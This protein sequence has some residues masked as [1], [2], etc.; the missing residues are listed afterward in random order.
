MAP[1]IAWKTQPRTTP[2]KM[3]G[4]AISLT[5]SLCTLAVLYLAAGN[6][7]GHPRISAHEAVEAVVKNVPPGL[8]IQGCQR[9]IQEAQRSCGV[10]AAATAGFDAAA[11]AAVREGRFGGGGASVRR[12]EISAPVGSGR[13][14]AFTASKRGV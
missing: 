3:D 12:R 8:G 9:I 5:L 10:T 6:N 1:P 7:Q 14:P 2:A 13:Q 11:V 4:Y